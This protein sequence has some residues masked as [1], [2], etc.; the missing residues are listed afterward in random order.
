MLFVLCALPHHRQNQ[1][2]VCD[3]EE[4]KKEDNV[5]FV[6]LLK[7]INGSAI[8]LYW[9]CHDN[10]RGIPVGERQSISIKIRPEECN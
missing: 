7:D 4:R 9:R 2:T 10:G 3:Q 8:V 1:D 5:S 6:S